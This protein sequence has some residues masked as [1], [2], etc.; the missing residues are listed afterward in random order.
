MAVVEVVVIEGGGQREG[1]RW[2]EGGRGAE[3]GSLYGTRPSATRLLARRKLPI[4]YSRPNKRHH[5]GHNQGAAE[6]ARQQD[7][8]GLGGC[9]CPALGSGGGG[10]G[11]GMMK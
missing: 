1:G 7:K 11:G 3:G 8:S 4:E 10:G 5:L 9:C 6:A 2:A